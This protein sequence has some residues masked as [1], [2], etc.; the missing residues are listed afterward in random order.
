MGLHSF[1]YN[2][3]LENESFWEVTWFLDNGDT[4]FNT[5]DTEIN[6]A[7][8]IEEDNLN[9]D[10]ISDTFGMENLAPGFYFAQIEDCLVEG[11]AL[12][13]EFDLRAEPEEIFLETIITQASCLNDD[14]ASACAQV[15]GGIPP[16]NFNLSM[17]DPND[18]NNTIQIPLN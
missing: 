3:C 14:G 18:S 2:I 1:P 5:L 13:V 9:G 15:N 4:E 12:I 7:N 10:N 16:Y 6:T 8:F 11:C 17:I